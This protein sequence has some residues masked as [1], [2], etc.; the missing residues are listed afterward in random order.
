MFE[1][2]EEESSGRVASSGNLHIRK[3]LAGISRKI[4]RIQS[5]IN[6]LEQLLAP[7]NK[8]IT[9]TC[10]DKYIMNIIEDSVKLA[11]IAKCLAP[12]SGLEL[13]D[14]LLSTDATAKCEISLTDNRVTRIR[15]DR[16]F[17]RK[18]SGSGKGK[19]TDGLAVYQQF[20]LPLLQKMHELH[21][22]QYTSRIV[23]AVISHYST[24]TNICDYDNQEI[25]KII[26]VLS[27][28][29]IKDDSP[30]F[31]S[32]YYDYMMDSSDYSELYLIPEDTFSLFLGEWEKRKT[33][34]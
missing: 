15:F 29:Y 18:L 34:P 17:P 22:E 7:D 1:F 9:V 26:D 16:L 31:C 23:I 13:L 3:I 33:L 6:S 5:S 11:D 10:T 14:I 25:A 19:N 24:E 32:F 27:T 28:G 12:A 2:V 8:S 4:N 21:P 20:A 30:K